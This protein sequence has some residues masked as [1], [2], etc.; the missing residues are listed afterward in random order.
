M[1]NTRRNILKYAALG[2]LSVGLG[3]FPKIS[4]AQT[5]K[6][7]KY[8]LINGG[9]FVMGSS[10]QEFLREKDESQHKVT[11]NSFYMGKYHVTQKEYMELMGNNPSEFKRGNAPVENVTWYDAV[12]Y[13][14][15]LSVKEGFTPVYSLNGRTVTW[16]KNADGY[17]LPTEAEWEYAARAGTT[18]PFY[19]GE[20]IT[21]KQA[22]WYGT[23]P[24]KDGVSGEARQRTIDVGSFAPNPWGLYDISGNVWEWCW[25]WYGQYDAQAQTDP[26]G[27]VE[28]VYKIHRGGAWNDFGRH[29]RLAYRAAFTPINRMYNIGFRVVRN[30]A[31]GGGSITSSPL[32]LT[33]SAGGKTLIL[34]YTWSGN[35]GRLAREIQ[36]ITKGDIVELKMET[37][38]SGN[39][40]TCLTQSRRDQQQNVRPA[41]KH[42]NLNGYDRIFLGY[43][44]WWATMPMQMWTFLEQNSN[45]LANKTI[46]PFA[47]HGEG[48]LG[49]TVSAIAKCVP[50]TTVKEAF[51]IMYSA[52]SERE[53]K[54]WLERVSR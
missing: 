40:N 7:D 18:T 24:Y 8:V 35:T 50:K 14:N 38:Y 46:I 30:A 22:N 41:V 37:P 20:N 1:K 29:L 4:F 23:Y 13:C 43:P 5:S 6:S 52:L 25:D 15:A 9:S 49:Q 32:P 31:V 19:T 47:S 26:S 12:E 36:K 16:N 10:T 54:A 17:R 51:S 33:P 39:Y 11:V 28:G 42:V 3:C 21:A 48:R 2:S 45:A 34:Y 53:M 44:T 27:P